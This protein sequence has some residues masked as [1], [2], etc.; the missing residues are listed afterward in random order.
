MGSEDEIYGYNPKTGFFATD[1]SHLSDGENMSKQERKLELLRFLSEYDLALPPRAIHR[2][3]RLHRR[4]F[5]SEGTV[6]NYIEE[7]LSEGYITRVDPDALGDGEVIEMDDSDDGRAYYL[8][9][10]DGAA[11]VDENALPER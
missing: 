8:I 1:T 2:N 6:D 7:L 4:M 3:I 10:T 9:T 5:I 11:L